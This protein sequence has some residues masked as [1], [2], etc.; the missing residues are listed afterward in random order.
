[1]SLGR[2]E[3]TADWLMVFAG[4][5]LLASLFMPWSH[6]LPLAFFARYAGTGALAGVP[7]NPDAW[8]VFS[9]VDV[10]LALLAAGLLAAALRGGRP[11]RAILLGALGVA[12]AFT[13]HALAVPPT[14]GVLVYDPTRSPPGYTPVAAGAGTGETVALLAL[15][16]GIAG[17]LLS[18][19]S[20]R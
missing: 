6:Q 13:V 1:V 3:S 9:A 7:P 4:V 17:A 8:Q 10:L 5:A 16:L 15:V 14:N 19:T 11:A 18:F 2:R 20:D 12:L